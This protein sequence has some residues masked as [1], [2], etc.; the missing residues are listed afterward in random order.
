MRCI[1]GGEVGYG[2]GEI[3]SVLSVDFGR[4]RVVEG[5]ND[6]LGVVGRWSYVGYMEEPGIS[7]HEGNAA[8]TMAPRGI[9][10]KNEG[11]GVRSI[12]K[13]DNKQENRP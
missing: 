11:V 12:N 1:F 6:R 5:G 4:M 9:W 13:C 3:I 10:G 7:L 8:G 2:R